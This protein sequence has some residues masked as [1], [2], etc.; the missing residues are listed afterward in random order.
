[1]G[2]DEAVGTDSLPTFMKKKSPRRVH[3]LK[4]IRTGWNEAARAGQQAI[5]VLA[6]G[7]F[8]LIFCFPFFLVLRRSAP[9]GKHPRGGRLLNERPKRELSLGELR[10]MGRAGDPKRD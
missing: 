9:W 3:I 8:Y 10:S 5:G 1:R 2:G 4:V 6:F 7:A